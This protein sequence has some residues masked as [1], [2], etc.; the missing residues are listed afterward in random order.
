[1]IN[2]RFSIGGQF[3]YDPKI[4]YD[5]PIRNINKLLFDGASSSLRFIITKLNFRSDEYALL[6]SYLC[7]TIIENFNKMNVKIIFYSINYDFSINLVDLKSKLNNNKIKAIYFIEYFGMQHNYETI[8]FL[9]M[10][11]SKGYTIIQDAVHTLYLNEYDNFIGTYCFNSLRKYGP[12]DGSILLSD[13]NLY[14]HNDYAYNT[15]YI[16]TIMEARNEKY[17]YLKGEIGHEDIFLNKFKRA[18]EFYQDNKEI[19]LLPLNKEK[20]LEKLN[21]EY[22]KKKR[23]ENFEFLDDYFK[24]KGNVTII[25]TKERFENSIPF[26]MIILIDSRDIVREKLFNKRIYC[27]ILWDISKCDYIKNF[28]ESLKISQRILMIPI[29][30]RYDI[31]DMRK[32]VEVFNEIV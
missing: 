30:Q 10:M 27:P 17:K 16:N 18:E 32:F 15:E 13:V 26:A 8:E 20:E 19:S 4:F 9:K 3:Q 6:P 23:I 21:L 31:E 1:M 24:E 29:D 28:K 22:I 7:P 25:T 5:T 11:K 14:L 12:I 2:S